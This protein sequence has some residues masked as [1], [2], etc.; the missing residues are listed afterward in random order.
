M[1][2]ITFSS[3]LNNVNLYA[4]LFSKAHYAL[5]FTCIQK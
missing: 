1:N 3:I 2:A 5:V 4:D